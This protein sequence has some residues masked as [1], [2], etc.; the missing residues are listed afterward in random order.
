MDR[1]AFLTLTTSSQW[2]LFFAI[3]LVIFSWVEKKKL[4]QLLGQGVFF[5]LGV[6][7]IWVIYGHRIE[8][9]E[10][11]EPGAVPIEAKAITYFW[12]LVITGLIGLLALVLSLLKSSWAKFPNLVLVPVGIALFFMVFALQRA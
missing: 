11:L 4:P 2:M 12:G 1:Q 7:A 10:H 6:F 8:V 3:A 9:P 5:I